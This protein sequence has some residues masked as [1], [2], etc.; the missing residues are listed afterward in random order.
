[1]SCC[2]L[3]LT[4]LGNKSAT[5]DI[6]LVAVAIFACTLK[7]VGVKKLTEIK[8]TLNRNYSLEIESLLWDRFHNDSM[9]V[10]PNA[11]CI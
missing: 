5:L 4:S 9:V 1:M 3:F 10:K 6:L 7:R 11:F 2:G 8:R